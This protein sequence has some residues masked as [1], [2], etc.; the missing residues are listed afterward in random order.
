MEVM[1]RH[2]DSPAHRQKLAETLELDAREFY[3]ATRCPTCDIWYVLS[4]LF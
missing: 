1:E 4:V 2:V 3:M